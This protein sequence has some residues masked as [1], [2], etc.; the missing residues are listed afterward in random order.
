ME[1][2]GTGNAVDNNAIFTWVL[3]NP[4][5]RAG[6]YLC[7]NAQSS[8]RAVTNFAL[9]VMTTAGSISIPTMQLNGR[10]SRFVVTDYGIGNASLLYSSAQVLTSG[11]FGES[12][13]VVFY[14]KVGQTGEFAFG[15]SSHA[16]SYKTYG[17]SLS[18]TASSVTGSVGY[19]KYS[20]VQGSGASVV[21]FSNGVTA[22]MLD[23][24]TAYT[25]FAPPTTSDPNVL[26]SQQIF[27][28]GS[29]LVRNASTNGDTVEISGDNAISSTIEVYIGDSNVSQISWNGS[30]LE[31]SKT[32]YGSLTAPLPGSQGRTV[33]LPALTNWKVA[34]SLPEAATTYDD[35]K[36]ILC[37]K[38]KSLSPVAPLTLPVL[39]SSDY[40][41]YAG[42]KLYR[43]YF[44]GKTAT[45]ANITVQGGT[46]SG[47]SAW[48]N[49]QFVGGS[50]GNASLAAT[51]VVLAF[52]N[53]TLN[54]ANNVLTVVT[55]YN[56]HDETS[57]SPAGGENPRGILGA[58]LS[59][60]GKNLSFTKWKIQGNAGGSSYIDPVRGPMNEGGLYGERL[61]W[62]L[63]GFDTSGW[64]SG[65]PADGL[66]K[67]G[68]NW[69][70]TTFNLD[71]DDDLDV[72][73]GIELGAPA[74]TVARVQLFVNG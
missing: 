25:F 44:D 13:V 65:S 31:T 41:F 61:G 42:I 56:G 19:T 50:P 30:P 36:W 39:F 72:P 54:T 9:T 48:L 51:S 34:N 53:I 49:G 20:Y 32:A 1:S 64:K 55:D 6:F 66:T 22:Y 11:T 24:S 7:E 33:S 14:L 18:L 35:S 21:Q 23:N 4:T 10:Q 17:Q 67:P 12:T 73:I 62:H 68:I 46:A 26:P 71:I 59:G 69:Y 43:G 74:G 58:I 63:P 40:G 16:A 45:S 37:N 70:S 5:T 60:G 3:R 52:S 38:T 2:N 28:L 8:S 27:V 15:S 57:V 47:W 29:Y